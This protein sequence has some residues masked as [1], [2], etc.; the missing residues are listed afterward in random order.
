MLRTNDT[1][2]VSRMARK[3]ELLEER[4]ENGAWVEDAD[5]PVRMTLI[6]PPAIAAVVSEFAETPH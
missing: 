5:Q 2:P 1:S 3:M 4:R 6:V